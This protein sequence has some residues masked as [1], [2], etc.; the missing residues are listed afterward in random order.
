MYDADHIQHPQIGADKRTTDFT[1][2]TDAFPRGLI[3]RSKARRR[4]RDDREVSG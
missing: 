3:T 1:D 4:E 2:V